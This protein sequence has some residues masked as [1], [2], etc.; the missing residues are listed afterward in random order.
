ME[1]E[2]RSV[3]GYEEIYEVSNVGRVRSVDRVVIQRTGRHQVWSGRIMRFSIQRGGY[4][5]VVLCNRGIQKT[6]LVHRLVALAFLPRPAGTFQVCHNDGNPANCNV[7]NLRWDTASGNMADKIKH[8]TDRQRAKT[9]CPHGHAYDAENTIID[10]G[11][12][13][14]RT[15]VYARNT[16]RY[17]AK[18]VK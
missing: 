5:K 11:A 13:K 9:H 4:L 12:R 10:N 6:H 3:V 2:W 8:G 7:N 15:C 18:K 16:A 1:E 14:C 17:H